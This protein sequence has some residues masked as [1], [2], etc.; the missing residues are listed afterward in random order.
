MQ[1]FFIAFAVFCG[2][3]SILAGPRATLYHGGREIGDNV[4]FAFDAGD[5]H[6]SPNGQR[7]LKR[8]AGLIAVAADVD[9]I[10][11]TKPG[12]ALE[13]FSLHT[14]TPSGLTIFAAPRGKRRELQDGTQWTRT[15]EA[16][17]RSPGVVAANPVFMDPQS[18]RWLVL[19]Q[20]VIVKLKPGVDS[21]TY[22]AGE[23][24]AVTPLGGTTDQFLVAMPSASSDEIFQEVN[25]RFDDN[26]VEWVEPDTIGQMMKLAA[27]N[28]PLFG[29][30][31]HLN[32]TGQGNGK[33]DA[34]VDA[35]EA[36]N[37]TTGSSNVVIAILDDSVEI[38]HPDLSANIFRNAGEIANGIDDDNN[39][40]VD[41]LHGWDFVSNDNDPSPVL[42]DDEHGVSCAGVAAAVGNNAEGVAGV[43]YNCRIL[44]IRMFGVAA[45]TLAQSIYYAAGRSRDGTRRWRG[46]DI[47]SMSLAFPQSSAVDTALAWA[48]TNGRGGKGC[49]IFVASG[50]EATRWQTAVLSDV[51]P[52]THTYEWR[53]IKDSSISA[54]S[55]TAWLD[56]VVF[57]DGSSESFEGT[58][59][60]AGWTTTGNAAWFS[61]QNNVG[62]NHGLIGWNGQASRA[63]RAGDIND[64]Q[65]SG[66]RVTKTAGIG[67]LMFHVWVSAEYSTS[68]YFDHVAFL[69]DGDVYF[70]IDDDPTAPAV[71]T[72]G[73]PANNTNAI[74]VG[75]STDF[76]FRSDYSCYAGKLDFVAPSDGGFSAIWTTDRTG[77]DGY[78]EG[79]YEPNFS[80]TSAACPL[81][82]GVGGLVLSANTNL[83]ARNVRKLMQATCDK[84]GNVTYASGTNQFY[85]YGRINAA[86]AVS[87]AVPQISSIQTNAST[88][89]IRFSSIAGWTY[90]L[91]RANA[92][93]GSWAAVQSNIAGTGNVVQLSDTR[94]TTPAARFYRLRV[95]P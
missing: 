67:A 2:A 71:T 47:L 87:N 73:Y 7:S 1:K 37:V 31:W 17:R 26:A 18:G 85:G 23:R 92:I 76:D 41:D 16:V 24:F 82:A 74:A 83:S 38:N 9:A 27:P 94:V 77:I 39:G 28:D 21:R 22:F 33:P 49:P 55:D 95:L 35:L 60:P 34:D 62:G 89:V 4:A 30:Q 68:A 93:S 91:E 64:N 75:A 11:L 53:Y 29:E 15:V 84:I 59:L 48:A 42:I 88:V 65:T 44:P 3:I 13:G 46:A 43:A 36:W 50:N 81:A 32:N 14:R 19:A 25:R 58:A 66:L 72:I 8:I 45:S 80:G 54:G 10:Q 63:V 79:D 6:R 40:Y 69:L 70:R 56:G 90:N 86:T 57:P 5:S 52:G 20:S 61:V 51:P 78:E 12:G